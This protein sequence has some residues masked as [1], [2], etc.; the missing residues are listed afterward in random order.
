ML[1]NNHGHDELPKGAYDV[2]MNQCTT[3]VNLSDDILFGVFYLLD[4]L[5]IISFRKVSPPPW[6]IHSSRNLI[7]STQTCRR[8]YLISRSHSV[9]LNA[10]RYI[11]HVTPHRHHQ[12]DRPLPSHTADELEDMVCKVIRLEKNWTNSSPKPTRIRQME[13]SAAYVSCLVPGGRWLLVGGRQGNGVVMCHDLASPV[14]TGRPLLDAFA[15]TGHR[16]DPR[17]MVVGMETGG[18]FY[19]GLSLIDSGSVPSLRPA[20]F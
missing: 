17:R 1:T 9:W 8:I 18:S 4:L 12:L 7:A 15:S 13:C 6:P 2:R 10:F 3:I 20:S 16:G 14:I 11:A 5:S 19:L